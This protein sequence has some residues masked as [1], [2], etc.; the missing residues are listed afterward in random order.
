MDQLKGQMGIREFYAIIVITVG[1]KLGDD[2]PTILFNHLETAAWM[3]PII[4][5][6]VSLFPLFLLLKTLNLYGNKNLAEI[7]LDLF[8][9]YLG[10]IILFILFAIFFSALTIDSATYGNLISTM[11]FTKT[12]FIII[13]ALSMALCAYGAKKGIKH[14][15]SVSWA[16]LIY[17][18]IALLV[19][20]L[21]LFVK[22]E[23]SFIFPIF[24]PG[25]WEVLKHSVTHSSI[26]VDLFYLALLFPFI[27]EKKSYKKGIW[28]GLLFVTIELS[29][30]IMGYVMLFDYIGVKMMNY[31]FHEAIRYFEIGFL[32]N[33]ETFFFPFWLVAAF[34]RFTVYL[35]LNALIFS[36]IFKIKNFNYL[37][38][39][40]ATLAVVLG[41]IPESPSFTL[42]HLREKLIY[43]TTPVF[44]I[45]PFVIWIFGRIKGVKN[46][47]NVSN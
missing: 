39:I 7:I 1:T 28:I 6:A 4:I 45:F 42:F 26:Y 10:F 5:G 24:G 11:Y 20:L 43:I 29:V 41:L 16:L 47:E 31:A 17:I 9:K 36:Y 40:M 34:L 8:G 12:P 35:Y 44:L 13:H 23:S 22:G 2:T 15:G 27:S 37:I 25:K 38:P 30:S 19:V 18:K 32:I 46:N 14:I 33:V 3:A 21:L